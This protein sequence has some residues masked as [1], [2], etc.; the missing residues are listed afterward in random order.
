MNVDMSVL[1]SA[2]ESV[3]EDKNGKSVLTCANAY[4]VSK[5]YNI[6]LAEIGK[7]CNDNNI[8]IGKCQLGCF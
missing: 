4:S 1:K 7:Y 2:I 6:P 3:I 8:K 5:K